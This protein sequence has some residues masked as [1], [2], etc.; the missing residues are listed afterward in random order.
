[1]VLKG[2]P[3]GGIRVEFE[4]LWQEEAVKFTNGRLSFS[5]F[6]FSFSLF[7][8]FYFSIFRT[9]RIRVRSDRSHCHISHNLMVWS[10]HWS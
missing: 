5:L 7:F 2:V 1:M 3:S 8:L 4:E 6:Y 9:A 10:Q